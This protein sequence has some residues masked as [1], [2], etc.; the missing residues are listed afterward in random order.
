MPAR[1]LGEEDMQLPRADLLRSLTRWLFEAWY[2]GSAGR[3]LRRRNPSPAPRG[4][5]ENGRGYT[6]SKLGIPMEITVNLSQQRGGLSATLE[7]MN[8]FADLRLRK[9]A[10]WP[11]EAAARIAAGVEAGKRLE[12]PAPLSGGMRV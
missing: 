5:E 9:T 1:E 6:K 12:W 2:G 4:V 10:P 11:A 3:R 7:C 8:A